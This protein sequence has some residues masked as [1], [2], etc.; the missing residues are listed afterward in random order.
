MYITFQ[1]GILDVL[2]SDFGR[3]TTEP[4]CFNIG[5]THSYHDM[6]PGGGLL[7]VPWQF[8]LD[9]SYAVARH[10]ATACKQT[11]CLVRMLQIASDCMLTAS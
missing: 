6:K 4:R 7:C 10:S 8:G 2:Q 9:F 11:H 1:V 3:L 5:K